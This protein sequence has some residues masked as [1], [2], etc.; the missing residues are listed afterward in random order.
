[1]KTILKFLCVM[2]GFVILIS[3]TGKAQNDSIWITN[4]S[5]DILAVGHRSHD[6]IAGGWIRKEG[7]ATQICAGSAIELTIH[8]SKPIHHVLW[9]NNQGSQ[10]WST[11]TITVTPGVTTDY[12]GYMYE[13]VSGSGVYI[14]MVKISVQLMSPPTLFNWILDGAVNGDTA[15]YCIGGEV[16]HYS[17][18]Q[19]GCTYQLKDFYTDADVG[20]PVI[21]TG[22]QFDFP[23]V[24]AGTYYVEINNGYCTVKHY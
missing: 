4:S 3:T 2:I 13:D 24:T 7:D 22:L 15:H 23:S 16:M 5:G 18:S 10:T 21:G 20:A 19:I 11:F 6:T 12:A 9:T 1:M 8:Y 17:N 14:G